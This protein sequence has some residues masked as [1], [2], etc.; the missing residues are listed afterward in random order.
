[1]IIAGTTQRFSVPAYPTYQHPYHFKLCPE[2]SKLA[3]GGWSHKKSI[4]GIV[5]V[6]FGVSFETT[7]AVGFVE[8]PFLY[9]IRL[10]PACA[11]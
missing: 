6:S 1:M 8:A 7:E 9:P 5:W 3:I 11:Y 2:A 10:H 4:W